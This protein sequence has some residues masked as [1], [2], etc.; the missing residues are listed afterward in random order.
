[1]GQNAYPL[2]RMRIRLS[3]RGKKANR[4]STVVLRYPLPWYVKSW[5]A[6]IKSTLPLTPKLRGPQQHTAASDGWACIPSL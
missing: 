4:V 2:I 3:G 1:M 6:I 5:A